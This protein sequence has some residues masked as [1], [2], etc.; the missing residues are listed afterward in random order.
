MPNNLSEKEREVAKAICRG[1]TNKQIAETLQIS[2]N[3]VKTHIQHIY[4]KLSVH[5]RTELLLKY[6]KEEAV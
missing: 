4:K 6:L 1:K 3:T 2:I 5:S